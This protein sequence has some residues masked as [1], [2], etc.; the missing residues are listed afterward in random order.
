VLTGI[1]EAAK[2]LLVK[3][4]ALGDIVH[5]LPFLAA[6]KERF[7]RAE[8]HWVVARGLHKFLEEHPLIH[9][10][11]VIDKQ[12][13][14]KL[15]R[16][17]ETAGEIASLFRSLRA[18]SFDLAVDLQGLLR[19]GLITRASRAPRRVGFRSAREGSPLFYTHRVTVRPDDHAI[20]R[21][22]A[23]AEYLGCAADDVRYPLPPLP[24]RGEL[25]F[26][27]PRDYA[28]LVPSAGKPANRWPAERFG[29]LAAMLPVESVVVGAGGDA[30]IAGQVVIASGGR[31]ISLAGRTGLKEMAAVVRDARFVVCNDTGPMHIAAAVGVPVFAIFGPAN[32][33]RTGPYGPIHT[34][35]REEMDCAPCYRKSPCRNWVCLEAVSVERVHEAITHRMRLDASSSP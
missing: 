34:V 31:A 13:W 16:I 8:V 30:D 19:S 22:L 2:V 23:V 24:G 3:P 15:W 17:R 26:E 32:P 5:T 11:W 7:P 28:V 29:K 33:D 4:S 27:L 10:L 21:N 25:D 6:L 1:P 18:E 20:R 14:K 9:R 12:H 35:I